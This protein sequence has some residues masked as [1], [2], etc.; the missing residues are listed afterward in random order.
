MFFALPVEVEAR[1]G[2]KLWV[3]YADGPEGVVDLSD[4]VGQGPYAAWS[5]IDFFNDVRIDSEMKV[6][7]WGN[8]VDICPDAVYLELTGMPFDQVFTWMQEPPVIGWLLEE[9]KISESAV[10]KLVEVKA[11]EG[12]RVWLCYDNGVSGELDLSY[13]AGKG[14]FKAWNDSHL[15]KDVYLLP[16][17]GGIA[18]SEELDMCA[19]ALYFELTGLS[20][21][22]LFPSL[23]QKSVN[24]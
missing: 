10:P 4:L 3:K 8:D 1:P 15:F 6:I 7:A 5:D 16:H 12:Y 18:G 21:E 11:G 20:P 14:V 22:D 23:R 13:L 24:A 17:G 19:D 2:Y 9:S